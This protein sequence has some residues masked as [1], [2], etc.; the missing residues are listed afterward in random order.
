MT[1]FENVPTYLAIILATFVFS[2]FVWKM[3]FLELD[4]Y[5]VHYTKKIKRRS[6]WLIFSNL[7]SLIIWWRVLQLLL[8]RL[9]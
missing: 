1:G 5:D 6:L 7:L 9:Q 4:V 8:S 2:F 3:L